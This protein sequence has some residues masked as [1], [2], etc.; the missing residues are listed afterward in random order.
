MPQHSF[1][2]RYYVADIYEITEN[3]EN[4]KGP[5]ELADW[6]RAHE[7]DRK[8]YIN[9]SDCTAMITDILNLDDKKNYIGCRIYKA[10]EGSI[11]NKIKEQQDP[12]PSGTHR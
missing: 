4:K 9:L 1:Q 3:G 11:P 8:M 5:F 7:N 2:M 10:R 6:L 12:T